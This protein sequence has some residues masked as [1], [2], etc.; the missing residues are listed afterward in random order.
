MVAWPHVLGQ[1]IMVVG[2]MT[3]ESYSP[4]GRWEAEG[5]RQEGA[6]DKMPLK[7]CFR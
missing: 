7:I 1:D 2:D 3:E 5:N 6:R 4:H